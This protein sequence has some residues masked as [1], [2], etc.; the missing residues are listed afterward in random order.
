MKLD[1]TL[2]LKHTTA[3][4]VMGWLRNETIDLVKIDAVED[5]SPVLMGVTWSTGAGV[6]VHI[7]SAPTDRDSHNE[8]WAVA[9]IVGGQLVL[10]HPKITLR[11]IR[12]RMNYINVT[13]G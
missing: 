13:V 8:N 4:L 2:I 5:N 1:T 9:S 10:R 7:T 3:K 11:F 12:G 6:R